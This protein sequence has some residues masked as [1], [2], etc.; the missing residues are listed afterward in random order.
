MDG[1]VDQIK[2]YA[3]KEQAELRV[4]IKVPG[5][6]F[7]WT[8]ATAAEQREQYEAEA[9]EYVPT[10]T[11]KATRFKKSATTDAIKFIC[12]SDA[13]EDAQHAGF[14]MSVVEWNRYRHYT[15]KDDRESEKVYI[16]SVVQADQQKPAGNDAKEQER[17][18]VYS[19]FIYQSAGTH[20]V[21]VRDGSKKTAPCEYWMCANKSGKCKH[22]VPFKVVSKATGKLLAHVKLC[23][24]SAYPA[25]ALESRNSSYEEDE[26]GE[27]IKRLSFKE[28][29]PH[30]AR[31]VIMTVLE[32]DHFNKCRSEA[33]KQYVKG[34]K[35]GADVPHPVPGL[36]LSAGRAPGTGH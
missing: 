22:R 18:P 5:S 33:R 35:K 4:R 28:M 26:S 3:G 17:P 21:K 7:G 29:L 2:Q 20:Q 6:W 14:I 8:S 30:H 34:L 24:P 15:Y 10:H 27:T 19:E 36:G 25:I 16:R 9:F 1:F 31:Y 32:W 11:F 23:H 13:A 12:Q